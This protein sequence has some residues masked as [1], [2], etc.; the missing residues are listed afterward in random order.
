[1]TTHILANITQKEQEAAIKAS[2]VDF[3][4]LTDDEAS[5]AEVAIV[6]ISTHWGKTENWVRRWLAAT[7]LVLLS[8]MGGYDMG[9]DQNQDRSMTPRILRGI[10][11]VRTG[12]R[13]A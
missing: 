11:P 9:D 8:F 10:R 2:K 13:E 4:E 6:E 12:R 7:F 5:D 3:M 1:M